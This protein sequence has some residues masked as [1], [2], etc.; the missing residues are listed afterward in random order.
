MMAKRTF[1]A[2]L[3]IAAMGSYLLASSDRGSILGTITDPQGA[4]IPGADVV[5]VNVDT[6]IETKLVTNSAGLFVALELV[7]GRYRVRITAI[8]FSPVEITGVVV[9]AGQ[10][11]PANT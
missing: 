2:L 3:L 10:S 9:T 11:T 6:G 4:V 8:G 5:V 1:I 7:P